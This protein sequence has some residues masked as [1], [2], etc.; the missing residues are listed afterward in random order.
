MSRSSEP[1][2]PQAP[3]KEE[4]D[5]DAVRVGIDQVALDHL[6]EEVKGFFGPLDEGSVR[7]S[8]YRMKIDYIDR[9]HLLIK[10]V[11][12][13]PSRYALDRV[14]AAWAPEIQQWPEMWKRVAKQEIK[15]KRWELKYYASEASNI[16]NDVLQGGS[17]EEVGPDNPGDGEG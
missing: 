2:A 16:P 6:I 11:R 14:Q 7:V 15:D 3:A 8:S 1:Y 13:A 9:W 5:P 4:A 12:G 10:A 17:G